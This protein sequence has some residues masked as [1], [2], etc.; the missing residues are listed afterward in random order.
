MERAGD[1]ALGVQTVIEAAAV[2]EITLDDAREFC[3]LLESRRKILE[4]SE[5]EVRIEARKAGGE[6]VSYSRE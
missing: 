1:I 3:A 2:G 4:T 5:L 6:T